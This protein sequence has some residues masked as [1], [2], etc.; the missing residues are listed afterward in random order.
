MT[1]FFLK[2]TVQTYI[3]ESCIALVPMLN[4]SLSQVQWNAVRIIVSNVL[5]G[6]QEWQISM[7]SSYKVENILYGKCIP[8]LSGELWNSRFQSDSWWV[9][10]EPEH[11]LY[12]TEIRLIQLLYAK[13]SPNMLILMHAEREDICD[14]VIQFLKM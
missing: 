10:K 7:H 2:V 1:G 3:L 12:I 4:I 6:N 5:L 13:H 9:Y 11:I 14:P 8:W